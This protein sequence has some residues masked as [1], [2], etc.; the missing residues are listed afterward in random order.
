M[1]TSAKLKEYGGRLIQTDGQKTVQLID[2]ND[3]AR[4]RFQYRLSQGGSIE[5]RVLRANGKPFLDT[6]SPWETFS[7]HELLALQAQRGQWHPILDS[8]GL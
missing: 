3:N 2:P 7:S 1:N 5:R 6:G 8:L 4:R